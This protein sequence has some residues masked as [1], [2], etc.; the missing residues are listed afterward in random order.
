LLAQ[1][2]HN[3]RERAA[4]RAARL[5]AIR[6]GSRTFYAASLLLPR[7][8][9]EPALALYAFC[10]MADDA[11]DR[12]HDPRAALT[13]LRE[14]LQLAADGTPYDDATD[15][16]L[17]HVMHEFRI[18]FDVPAALLEGFAWD[19]E[20]R[21][22]R[23]IGELHDYCARVAGTVGVMMAL[24]MGARSS[25]ALARAADLGVAMQLSNIARDVGEDAR[26]ERLYLPL[27]WLADTSVDPAAFVAAPEYTPA[28]GRTIAR[29]VDAASELY[30]RAIPGIAEL[31]ASCRPAIHAARLM[32]AEIGHEVERGVDD[33]LHRRA[34][35]SG[36]RKLELLVKAFAAALEYPDDSRE[37]PLAATRY[38]VQAVEAH[39]RECGIEAATN[40]ASDPRA[41][42]HVDRILDIFERL[43]RRDRLL[44]AEG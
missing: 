26:A 14:R 29:L 36:R 39:D 31:P 19:A 33:G 10:R 9:R 42:G 16:G 40:S 41:G 32:Y 20:G 43:E 28:L 5:A 13:Q 18:P 44:Q 34:V 7:R 17:A 38:L 27:E 25:H 30:E 11:I 8:V 12:S 4:D 1:L 35:V 21:R 2:A 3:E 6:T 15:R 23:T 22:Y 24:L 37:P